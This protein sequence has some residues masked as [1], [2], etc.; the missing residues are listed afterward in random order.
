MKI[1]KNTSLFQ[2]KKLNSLFCHVH[3]QLAKDEGRLPHWKSLKIQVMDKVKGRHASGCAY[4]GK[5]YSRGEP[6]MWCSYNV[7]TSLERMAQLFAHELM[8]SYGYRHSQFRSNPLDPHHIEEINKKFNK[9]DFYKS[10]VDKVIAKRKKPTRN[11]YNACMD[12]SARYSW[13]HFYVKTPGYNHDQNIE[14]TDERLDFEYFYDDWLPITD[15]TW[16]W[17]QAYKFAQVL[18]TGNLQKHKTENYTVGMNP[19]W[20]E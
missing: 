6:D 19:D 15:G 13:L 14:V 18:I 3:N 10:N 4:V 16:S 12:L 9:N 17:C 2:T 20:E 11:Y 8:H 5:V 1:I 7:E